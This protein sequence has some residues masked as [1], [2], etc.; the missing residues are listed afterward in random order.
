MRSPLPQPG[1]TNVKEG[2]YLLAVNGEPLD[3]DED[4]WAAFQGLAGQAVFLTVNDKPTLDGAREVAGRKR[5]PA[6]RGCATWRGSRRTGSASR[7]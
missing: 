3:A 7:S 1:L 6:R 4:P 2:D 5:S